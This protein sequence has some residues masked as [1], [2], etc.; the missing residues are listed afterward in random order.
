MFLVISYG[1]SV[2][3]VKLSADRVLAF[4]PADGQ[5]QKRTMCIIS[6]E[7][8]EPDVCQ[9]D[10]I[11]VMATVTLP[12]N[13]GTEEEGVLFKITGLRYK[14]YADPRVVMRAAQALAA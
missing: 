8:T 13:P 5:N 2:R 10:A 7:T 12:L 9:G 6:T 1:T 11:Q 3:V 14:L 4:V